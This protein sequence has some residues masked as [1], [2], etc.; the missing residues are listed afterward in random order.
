[1]LGPVLFNIFIND[2]EKGI[3]SEV[4]IALGSL[5]RGGSMLFA[6]PSMA[7]RWL[8]EAHL[9]EVLWS[10]RFGGMPAGGLPVLHHRCL[11]RRI[12]AKAAGPAD[13]PQARCQKPPAYGPHSEQQ[14]TPPQLAAPRH[15]LAV[16]VPGAAPASLALAH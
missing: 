15:V 12:A 13:L 16:L 10:H 14:A 7:D 8:L 11:H 9:R 3:N 6:A 4:L 2:L 5:F 1:V